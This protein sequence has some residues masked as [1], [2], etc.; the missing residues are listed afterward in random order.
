MLQG[1]L[2][3]SVVD[4]DGLVHQVATCTLSASSTRTTTSRTSRGIDERIIDDTT[5]AFKVFVLDAITIK[6]P[7]ERLR[8]DQGTEITDEESQSYCHNTGLKLKF[9]RTATPQQ[10][11]LWERDGRKNLANMTRRTLGDS[12]LRKRLWEN[13]CRALHTW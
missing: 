3:G 12:R 4:E 1:I 11:E 9:A 8:A 13:L 7:V 10:V 6:L 2:H 5:E